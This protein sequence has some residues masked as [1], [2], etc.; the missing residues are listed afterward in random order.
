[1]PIR[2]TDT[3]LEAKQAA[4]NYLLLAKSAERALRNTQEMLIVRRAGF[5]DLDETR[6]INAKLPEI[7]AAQVAIEAE[8][9]AFFAQSAAIEPPSDT[10]VKNAQQ[11]A[12]RL[13]AMNA[14]SNNASTILAVAQ[15]LAQIWAST[16]A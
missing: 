3:S 15:Q 8:L 4:A 2:V 13:D 6:D 16:R 1:M 9:N 12:E 10:D 5:A 14:R 11:L 7:V